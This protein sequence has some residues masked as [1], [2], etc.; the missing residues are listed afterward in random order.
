MPSNEAHASLASTFRSLHRPGDPLILANVYDAA[1]A[2]AIAT[3]PS[4]RALATASW[5]VAAAAGCPDS[6]LDMDTNLSAVRAIARVAKQHS[7]PLTVDFQDGYGSRLEKGIE[8]LLACEGVVV[9][10]NLEDYDRER[11]ALYSIDEA[12]TR[13]KKV[14]TV[15]NRAGIDDFVVNARADPL[16]HGG[17]IAECIARGK[18][19]LA[20]GATTVFVLGGTEKRKVLTREEITQLVKGFGSMLN[21][22]LK[23][24]DGNMTAQELASLSVARISM[25]PELHLAAMRALKDE[26]SRAINWR[27]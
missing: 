2:A 14:L 5:A 20:A 7:L 17:T 8:A 25:G 6:S 21:V 3:L 23:I 1:S 13:I 4:T 16:L 9:G 10:V 22:G 12:V 26:A 24:G 11:F 27:K 18:A 19:Y 15:A